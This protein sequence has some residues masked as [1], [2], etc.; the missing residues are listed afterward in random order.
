MRFLSDT[1]KVEF[2]A[3]KSG[4]AM[5]QF[6]ARNIIKVYEGADILVYHR[7]S[8]GTVVFD[9][10]LRCTG[11][12]LTRQG[13]MVTLVDRKTYAIYTVIDAPGTI[14]SY[15]MVVKVPSR[16]LIER[17]VKVG[18]GGETLEGVTAMIEFYTPVS[19]GSTRVI[20]LNSA[21]K[22]FGATAFENA[23]QLAEEG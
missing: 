9:T 19:W 10:T 12:L 13:M 1:E 7:E 3:K 22:F 15:G 5:R 8:G 18:S 6:P 2:Y 20:S 17:T 16:C 14:G 21:A 4:V 23:I 11:L